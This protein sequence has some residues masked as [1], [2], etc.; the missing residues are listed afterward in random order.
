MLP[1]KSKADANIAARPERSG[2]SAHPQD[3]PNG[4]HPEDSRRNSWLVRMISAIRRSADHVVTRLFFRVNSWII[5]RAINT[6]V[7]IFGISYLRLRENYSL[8]LL[9]E[10]E[11]RDARAKA[12]VERFFAWDANSTP[13]KNEDEWVQWLEADEDSRSNRRLH[14]RIQHWIRSSTDDGP[15]IRDRYRQLFDEDIEEI[16]DGSILVAHDKLRKDLK[17]VRKRY[18]ASIAWRIPISVKDFAHA[19]PILSVAMALGGYLYTSRVHGHFGVDVSHFFTVGDY[20]ASAVHAV[21]AAAWSAFLFVMSAAWRAVRDLNLPEYERTKYLRQEKWPRRVFYFSCVV[22]LFTLDQATTLFAVSLWFVSLPIVD[23]LL[24]QTYRRSLAVILGTSSMVVFSALIYVESNAAIQR[25]ETGNKEQ[26]FSIVSQG[27]D[28]T[29]E[30]HSIIGSSN[31][32]LFLWVRH[33][34][35]VQI[36]PHAEISRMS[37]SDVPE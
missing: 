7:T 9:G 35:R 8:P 15:R 17:V 13:G 31:K 33:E 30:T 4:S 22:G 14:L 37:F 19:I 3:S 36:I 29:S 32:Y 23:Y 6:R 12:A 21:R 18:L 26:D 1:P 11:E 25:V 24:N 2:G 34:S 20:L 27:S 16:D 10:D 5:R 28:L